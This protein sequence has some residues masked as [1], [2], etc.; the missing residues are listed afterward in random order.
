MTFLVPIKKETTKKD[1]DGYDKIEKIS[2]KIK[3]IDS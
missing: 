2:R 3:F 1:K